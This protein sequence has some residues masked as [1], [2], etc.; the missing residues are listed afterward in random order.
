MQKL[1]D[2]LYENVPDVLIENDIGA[3]ASNQLNID[4]KIN[5]LCELMKQRCY[6]NDSFGN[7]KKATM[8]C[9]VGHNSPD[10]NLKS[11]G[12]VHDYQAPYKLEFFK[13]FKAASNLK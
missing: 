5:E 11:N 8:I 12:F 3:R 7:I 10:Q 13:L 4:I 2:R 1:C 6:L 9:M